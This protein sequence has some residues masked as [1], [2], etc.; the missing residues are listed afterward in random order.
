MN[1]R[2]QPW[3]SLCLWVTLSLGVASVALAWFISSLPASSFPKLQIDPLSWTWPADPKEGTSA[4]HNASS[5]GSNPTLEPSET[6]DIQIILDWNADLIERERAILRLVKDSPSRAEPILQHLIENEYELS[7]LRLAAAQGLAVLIPDLALAEILA[8]HPNQAVARGA[9]RGIAGHEAEPATELLATLLLDPTVATLGRIEAAINLSR[10]DTP[11]AF[12]HLLRATY[13]AID[14]GPDEPVLHE[15]LRE[16]VSHHYD[17]VGGFID[18]LLAHPDMDTATKTATLDGMAHAP[19]AGSLT[20]LLQ[21]ARS[22]DPV[23]REAAFWAIAGQD[24]SEVDQAELAGL[25]SVE[26]VPWVRSTLYEALRHQDQVPV[27]LLW[28]QIVGETDTATRI[29]GYNLLATHLPP[30]KVPL[31]GQTIVPELH[32]IARE[33][34]SL[35]ERVGAIIVLGRA[36]QSAGAEEALRLLAQEGID[37]ETRRAAQIALRDQP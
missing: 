36:Q 17:K 31:F 1:Y 12:E 25:L 16:L 7:R 21:Q 3:K 27:H 4:Q 29:R 20:T 28:D 37:A 22:A 2:I 30:A 34:K 6:S 24:Y 15:V 9:V 8:R 19:G 18:G 13:S 23:V 35:T 33:N 32:Q 11:A 10:L 26:S 5:P 14:L